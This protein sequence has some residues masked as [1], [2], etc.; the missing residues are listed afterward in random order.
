MIRLVVTTSR[1]VVGIVAVLAALDLAVADEVPIAGNVK[2]VDTTAGTF[3]VE[4]AA[5]GTVRQVTIHMRSDSRIVRFV[6]STDASK[7]GFTE[8]QTALTDLKPGWTVS[9]KTRH[10]GDKEVAEVVRVVHE[11]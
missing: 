5:R 3:V 6:R 9:V 7:P 2:A 11:R 8:Q 10:E 1:A 4:S